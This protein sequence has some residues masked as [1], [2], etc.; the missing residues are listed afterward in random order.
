MTTPSSAG[1]EG[2]HGN[3]D[4]S[5]PLW[6]RPDT[7]VSEWPQAPMAAPAPQ[8]PPTPPPHRPTRKTLIAAGAGVGSRGPRGHCRGER[9]PAG[10]QVEDRR[11]PDAHQHR[12]RRTDAHAQPDRPGP[13]PERSRPGPEQ[14]RRRRDERRPGGCPQPRHRP[15]PRDDAWPGHERPRAGPRTRISPSDRRLRPRPSPPASS[16]S[17]PPSATTARQGA[18]TGVVLT[19][20]GLVLTN[21]H[22]V[23]G[24]TSLAVTDIGNG[25]TYR[26]QGARLRRA[27]TTSRSSSWSAPPA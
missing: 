26:R 19:A 23:A 17:S 21:H 3:D 6:G 4:W 16:T 7:V 27:R 20:D 10:P 2:R 11:V 5:S 15:Q 24:S 25:K 22:V 9:C 18:G 8:L 12:A 14:R 13:G 1:P